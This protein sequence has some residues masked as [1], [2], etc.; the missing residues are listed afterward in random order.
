MGYVFRKQPLP[1]IPLRRPNSGRDIWNHRVWTW[2]P[3][4][5][6]NTPRSK[7]VLFVWGFD[8]Y[9]QSQ[10]D[11]IQ[12]FWN[13]INRRDLLTSITDL[14]D[15]REV[16]VLMPKNTMKSIEENGDDVV[17]ILSEYIAR[18]DITH[19][20]VIGLSMG[21]LISKYALQKMKGRTEKIRSYFSYDTPHRGANVPL[22]VQY[23]TD[24]LREKS[25]HAKAKLV[26]I[27]S[28]AAREALFYHYTEDWKDQ[29]HPLRDPKRTTLLNTL[30]SMSVNKQLLG[31]IPGRYAIAN[32]DTDNRFDPGT[33]LGHFTG[34]GAQGWFNAIG[35]DQRFIHIWACGHKIWHA[36]AKKAVSVDGMGG[37]T[38]D[39]MYTLLEGLKNGLSAPVINRHMD[40]PIC[41]IP[42]QSALDVRFNF[43][44]DDTEANCHIAFTKTFT[45]PNSTEHVSVHDPIKAFIL[46]N[47]SP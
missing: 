30:S 39:Y 16:A 44:D 22:C 12:Y 42:N 31:H 46:D 47:L 37:G 3:D 8:P 41:F 14:R 4:G 45:M 18:P 32:G 15:R 13:L 6:P 25:D 29:E 21:G 17:R 27:N 28:D 1:D 43:V 5:T 38:S 11:N 24:Y 2:Y 23:A 33:E 7:I 19:I 26:E 40:K 35:N 10:I 20:D 9:G 36:T 34:I